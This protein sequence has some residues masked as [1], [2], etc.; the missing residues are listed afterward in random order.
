[1]D[2]RLA[3]TDLKMVVSNKWWALIG[4]FLFLFLILISHADFE[5]YLKWVYLFLPVC[6]LPIVSS[7]ISGERENKFL[8]IVFT[9]PIS[10]KEYII[11]KFLLWMT[12][13]LIYILFTL[14]VSFIHYIFIGESFLL[15][16]FHY[17]VASILLMCFVSSL[18]IFISIICTQEMKISLIIGFLVTVMFF[19]MYQQFPQMIGY[20]APL[21]ILYLLH[22]SPLVP[23]GDFLDIWWFSPGPGLEYKMFTLHPLLS[24]LSLVLFS[25]FLL[26]SSYLIFKK[27]QNTER[28]DFKGKPVVLLLVAILLIVP[29]FLGNTGYEKGEER[30]L[31]IRSDNIGFSFSQLSL[32]YEGELINTKGIVSLGTRSE[33]NSKS[34]S[35]VSTGTKGSPYDQLTELGNVSITL[36]SDDLRFIPNKL[37]FPV[38]ELKATDNKKCFDFPIEIEPTPAKGAIHASYSYG[39]TL[40]SDELKGS[41]VNFRVTIAN[42]YARAFIILASFIS[43]LLFSC[44]SIY[45]RKKLKFHWKDAA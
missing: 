26:F 44:L 8:N 6:L 5:N 23:L 18:G 37:E 11:S 27:L 28:F 22:L 10:K 21:F 42:K 41:V 7:S 34:V 39:M 40:V 17:I 2:L 3:K 12:V 14:P 43:T 33:D 16:L 36:N 38:V 29:M 24:M 45:I 30:H 35:S 9:T 32:T 31:Y 15:P 1:M 4:C 19:A 20:S 25:V 13:G